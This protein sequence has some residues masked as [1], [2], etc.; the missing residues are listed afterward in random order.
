MVS[1]GSC[2]CGRCRALCQSPVKVIIH[3]IGPEI[4][5]TMGEITSAFVRVVTLLG[6]K[7][8]KCKRLYT[9]L[10]TFLIHMYFCIRISMKS[11]ALVYSFM[12][13]ETC[14]YVNAWSDLP[15]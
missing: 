9:I 3:V 13:S 4:T 7:T 14:E 2:S 1:A 10:I 6:L 11:N 12:F 15:F 8:Q 5:D